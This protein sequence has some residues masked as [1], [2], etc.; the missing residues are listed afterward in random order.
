MGACTAI[1]CLDGHVGYPYGR[2][3]I[4]NIWESRNGPCSSREAQAKASRC[5]KRKSYII[6]FSGK[7]AWMAQP[8][9]V[10][11]IKCDFS[12]NKSL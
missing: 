10:G 2:I 9:V 5:L 11:S 3:P 12:H 4:R 8:E 1:Y 6:R 7:E